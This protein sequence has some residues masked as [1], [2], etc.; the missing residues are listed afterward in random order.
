MSLMPCEFVPDPSEADTYGCS[1][2]IQCQWDKLEHTT[3]NE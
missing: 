1:H 3:K 2:P